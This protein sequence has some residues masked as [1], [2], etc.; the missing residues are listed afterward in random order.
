GLIQPTEIQRQMRQA[1]EVQTAVL[2]DLTKAKKEDEDATKAQANAY[3]LLKQRL[4]DRMDEMQIEIDLQDRDAQA[5]T[6][7]KTQHELE[8]PARKAGLDVGK[9]EIAQ[10]AERYAATE[11]LR[12][13]ARLVGDLNFERDQLGRTPTEAA[14][15]QR[16][17]GAGLPIDLDSNVAS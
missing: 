11:R 2:G 3:E 12:N 8:R 7:L 4:K 1:I 9:E 15:A 14:V 6:R 13:Q 16:L 10:L 17:R 5:V